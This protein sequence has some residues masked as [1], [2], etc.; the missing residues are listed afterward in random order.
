MGG[1]CG[2]CQGQFKGKKIYEFF[3]K[4]LI[5]WLIKNN[6]WYYYLGA[7]KLGCFL[8]FSWWRSLQNASNL[9]RNSRHPVPLLGRGERWRRFF[10]NFFSYF[11]S[12]YSE[13]F[14][15]FVRKVREEFPK[16]TIFAGNVVSENIFK[17]LKKTSVLEQFIIFFALSLKKAWFFK[18]YL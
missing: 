1:V 14:V 2:A 16:H 13:S 3:N 4:K 7:Q 12:G 5:D 9:R 8:G 11:S 17:I 6:N 18:A 10:H 15:D